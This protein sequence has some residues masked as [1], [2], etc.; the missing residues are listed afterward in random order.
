MSTQHPR[1]SIGL[2][3]YNGENFL[4]EAL[5]SLLA[6]TF[7][8]FELIISDNASTDKTRE[9]CEAYAAQDARIHYYCN[10]TNIGGSRNFNRVFEMARGTYFKWAAHDDI[11]APT[12]LE[13]C[14]EVLDNDPE[15]ILC[16][17]RGQSIDT[18]GNALETFPPKPMLNSSQAHERFHE[19]INVP[20][21]LAS[22]FGVMR[23]EVL[24]KTRLMGH[25]PS[26][27]RVLLGELSIRGRFYEVPEVLFLNR[28]HAKRFSRAFPGHH[29][30]Q[31]WFEPS[32]KKKITFPHW[33]ILFEHFMS[34][35]R[36]C[37]NS[38]E[39]TQCYR[40]CLWWMRLHWRYLLN[41]L[42]LNDK[43]FEG[44]GFLQKMHLKR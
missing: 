24:Q 36:V 18:Y 7:T 35:S 40:V 22:I 5:D 19:C 30:Y 4:A 16:W 11:C 27:D 20:H 31:E 25:Y 12:F 28:N 10:E 13:R 3:V 33:R 29:A 34:A 6:Q 26:S 1:V 8:D 17:P 2:P 9:I 14:V 37:K 41:N 15:V 23:T 38:H 44:L 21:E 32:R 43:P 42:L 39:R